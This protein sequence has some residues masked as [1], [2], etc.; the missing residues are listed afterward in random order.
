MIKLKTILD[1][2]HVE[3]PKGYKK[4]S[5]IHVEPPKDEFKDEDEFIQQG[6]VTSNTEI[7]PETGKSTSLVKHLPKFTDIRKTIQHYNEEFKPFKYS[8]DEDLQFLGK[9]ITKQLNDVTRLIY[10]LEKRVALKQ[11]GND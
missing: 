3:K 2:V 8:K 6:F 1:E 5:S 4:P 11:M 9:M 7:D 10:A